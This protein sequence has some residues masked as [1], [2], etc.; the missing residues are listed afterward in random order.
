MTGH[1]EGP[2]RPVAVASTPASAPA[3][4]PVAAAPG[5][6][7]VGREPDRRSE[8]WQR[9]AVVRQRI[10]RLHQSWIELVGRLIAS[11]ANVVFVQ[12]A[13]LG[14]CGDGV[15]VVLPQSVGEL[16]VRLDEIDQY[17]RC[18][19]QAVPLHRWHDENGSA[20]GDIRRV[21]DGDR[22]R[23]SDH[24]LKSRMTM[25]SSR[26]RRASIHRVALADGEVGVTRHGPS[27]RA[28]APGMCPRLDRRHRNPQ[29]RDSRWE[30]ACNRGC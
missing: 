13:Q 4:S 5:R 26:C 14:G 24:D 9:N 20:V 15:A 6:A 25:E 7:D 16:A 28:S 8:A 11:G 18:G 27:R 2:R 1:V 30:R 12:I 10:Q 17:V 19:Q 21:H 3:A 29:P 22:V 23:H